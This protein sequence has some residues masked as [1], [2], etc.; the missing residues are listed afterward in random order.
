MV[1]VAI[2]IAVDTSK[3]ETDTK[4]HTPYLNILTISFLPTHD[5]L[6]SSID[7]SVNKRTLLDKYVDNILTY[8]SIF[9]IIIIG[10]VKW[11]LSWTMSEKGIVNAEVECTL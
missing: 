5:R 7:T 2:T 4:L 6:T 11:I 3:V 1:L 9:C 10:K 8:V